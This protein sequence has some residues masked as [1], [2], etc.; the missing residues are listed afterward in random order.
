MT[1]EDWQLPLQIKMHGTRNLDEGFRSSSLDFFVMLSSLSGVIGT[2]GQ[3]N[4]AAGNTYQDEF[5]Q[6]RVDSRTA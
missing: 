4:Y 2:R 5:A 3:A 6:A 1:G